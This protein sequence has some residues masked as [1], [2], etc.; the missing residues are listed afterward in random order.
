MG[1]LGRAE[2]QRET[3]AAA[4]VAGAAAALFSGCPTEHLPRTR[5]TVGWVCDEL[6]AISV[7]LSSQILTTIAASTV[8]RRS[9]ASLDIVIPVTITH[10]CGQSHTPTQPRAD[11]SARGMHE[12]GPIR[13]RASCR[14][15]LQIFVDSNVASL[16]T[17]LTL[18]SAIQLV[19]N[20]NCTPV[21][22]CLLGKIASES[23]SLTLYLIEFTANTIFQLQIAKQLYSSPFGDLFR[24]LADT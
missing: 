8:W 14:E 24:S 21:R 3:S 11:A 1:L 4:V 13:H 15:L 19:S 10:L 22:G 16:S 23:A 12:V 18:L 20:Y 7:S 2:T 9:S 5:E 6:S 17:F